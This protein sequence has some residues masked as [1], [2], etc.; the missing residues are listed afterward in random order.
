MNRPLVREVGQS[1]GLFAFTA[2]ATVTPV[3]LGLLVIRWF[4]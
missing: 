4:A 2:F 3:G 1:L